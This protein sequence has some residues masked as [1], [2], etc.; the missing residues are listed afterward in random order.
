MK[1]GCFSTFVPFRSIY[2]EYLS[3]DLRFARGLS[4]RFPFV[5]E[6]VPEFTFRE[7]A[8]QNN[9][10]FMRLLVAFSLMKRVYGDV[11]PHETQIQGHNPHETNFRGQNP[12]T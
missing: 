1:I 6:I 3:P 7:C 5:R 11:I 12:Y 9:I 4:L 2:T 8:K 10:T